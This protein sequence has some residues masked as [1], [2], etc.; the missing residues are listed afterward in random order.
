MT[1]VGHPSGPRLLHLLLLL[2]EF[3][4]F[5][6]ILLSDLTHDP[7]KLLLS[8]LVGNHIQQQSRVNVYF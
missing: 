4:L 5:I 2:S 3:Q 8:L 6:D 1:R 7:L